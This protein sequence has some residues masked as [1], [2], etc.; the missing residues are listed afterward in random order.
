M[1]STGVQGKKYGV[2]LG[3]NAAEPCATTAGRAPPLQPKH[4]ARLRAPL[5]DERM[6]VL[7]APRPGADG[8][9]EIPL[10]Q[11]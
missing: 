2:T 4:V 1:V 10:D 5:L 7:H 8:N 9:A 11:W 3:I 6:Y